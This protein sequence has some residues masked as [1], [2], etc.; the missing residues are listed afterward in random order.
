MQ[1]TEYS[2]ERQRKFY[3]FALPFGLGIL[4]AGMWGI[5]QRLSNIM[6][7]LQGKE[8]LPYMIGQA[9]TFHLIL[10]VYVGTMILPAVGWWLGWQITGEKMSR[11]IRIVII[12]SEAVVPVIFGLILLAVG[13]V[14]NVWLRQ[15]W[16]TWQDRRFVWPQ[17]YGMS[18]II[19]A[20][21]YLI[22]KK[23]KNKVKNA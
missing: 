8:S 12:L 4:W 9:L 13:S 1:D 7:S 3:L 14:Y 23:S 15:A 21:S 10:A 5:L 20:I 11:K 16:V 22:R 18:M 17:I 6:D 2:L 19:W